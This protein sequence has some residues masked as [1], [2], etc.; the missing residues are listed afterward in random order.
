MGAGNSVEEDQEQ[1]CPHI[2]VKYL[3]AHRINNP[4]NV[5]GILEDGANGI[6][7]DV[8]S[9]NK[10]WYVNHD[11]ASGFEVFEYMRIMTENGPSPKVIYL[12]IKTPFAVNLEALGSLI[13]IY[14]NI[15]FL[16]GANRNS[17]QLLRLPKEAVL[18]ID[19]ARFDRLERVAELMESNGRTYW[20]GDG[21]MPLLPKPSMHTS[22]KRIRAETKAAGTF[23]W[24]Y[25]S[26]G[27]W[28]SDLVLHK[29]DLTTITPSLVKAAAAMLKSCSQI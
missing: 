18:A 7:I 19:L 1:V 8:R 20:L 23:A 24:T 29:L 3:V 5:K 4:Y 28:K 9:D 21:N 14:P 27:A 17:D 12:D 16:F 10:S 26:L 6:E 22:F 25:S 15:L 2:Q 11:M 13:T